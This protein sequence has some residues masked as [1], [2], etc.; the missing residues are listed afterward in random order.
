MCLTY[1]YVVS[2]YILLADFSCHHSFLKEK[3]NKVFWDC[4]IKNVDIINYIQR[5]MLTDRKTYFIFL[6]LQQPFNVVILVPLLGHYN[7]SW[8]DDVKQRFAI[9]VLWMR[10]RGGMVVVVILKL[11]H[12]D[13]QKL[14]HTSKFPFKSTTN[15]K[16]HGKTSMHGLNVSIKD[17]GVHI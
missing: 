1:Q 12:K 4:C 17:S 8:A 16:F 6:F 2:F 3:K 10:E 15:Y 5:K 7:V 13:L 11:D 9:G 14:L